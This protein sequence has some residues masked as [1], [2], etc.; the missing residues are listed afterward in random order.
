MPARWC[1]SLWSEIINNHAHLTTI[2]FFRHQTRSICIP[3]RLCSP[4]MTSR[5][6]WCIPNQ[7]KIPSMISSLSLLLFKRC[8]L[9][10]Y[11]SPGSLHGW[12]LVEGHQ[13]QFTNHRSRIMHSIAFRTTRRW[14]SGSQTASGVSSMRSSCSASFGNIWTLSSW[15]AYAGESQPTTRSGQFSCLKRLR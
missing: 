14:R 5:G 15:K 9:T 12:K 13:P 11:H 2:S 3:T 6:K 7:Q 4:C 8:K 10:S 1:S